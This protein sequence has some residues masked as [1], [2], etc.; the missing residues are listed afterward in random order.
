MNCPAF[1]FVGSRA[2]DE[3]FHVTNGDWDDWDMTDAAVQ[4]EPNGYS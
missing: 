2:L 4:V 1:Q 3:K